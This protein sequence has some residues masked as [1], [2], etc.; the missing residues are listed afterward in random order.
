M[1][2]SEECLAKMEAFVRRLAAAEI[3]PVVAGIEAREIVAMLP[4]PVDPDMIE[5]REV[6]CENH[7][8][9][10][11]ESPWHADQAA[12]VRSGKV[13]NMLEVQAAYHG[14]KRGRELA[15]R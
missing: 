9:R 10:H 12:M 7:H 13:D 3:G 15:Q 5:A 11:P 6:V 1:K 4:K 2:T 14:I 8:D